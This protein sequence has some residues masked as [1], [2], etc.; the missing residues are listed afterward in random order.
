M[1]PCHWRGPT[2]ESDSCTLA[3]VPW[4]HPTE[5]RDLQTCVFIDAAAEEG[6]ECQ[7]WWGVP[8]GARAASGI[9]KSGPSTAAGLT[10]TAP[11]PP[12]QLP[13]PTQPPMLQQTQDS[14]QPPMH[15][16]CLQERFCELGAGYCAVEEEILLYQSYPH[17]L[18]S[19]HSF[20]LG[21]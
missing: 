6:D 7:G 11:G 18:L 9:G 4:Q 14:T 13:Q 10:S 16:S 19:L 1:N 12:G 8:G 3:P 15:Q 5:L 2:G 17:L 21:S 20:L